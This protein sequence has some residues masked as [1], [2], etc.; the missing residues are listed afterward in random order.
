MTEVPNRIERQA[1][2]FESE[3]EAAL[4]P[5]ST[6]RRAARRPWRFER[7]PIRNNTQVAAGQNPKQETSESK[8]CARRER[9]STLNYIR[10]HVYGGAAV[11]ADCR[12]RRTIVRAVVV[13]VSLIVHDE[14][15]V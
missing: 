15:P 7:G 1:P 3:S 6:S 11:N 4:E 2:D 10:R 12:T 14:R 9:V 5:K 13:Y 8:L